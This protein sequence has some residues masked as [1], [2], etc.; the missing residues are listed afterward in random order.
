M[1]ATDLTEHAAR[2]A[3]AAGKVPPEIIDSVIVGN[4]MQV[5]SMEILL[6]GEYFSHLLHCGPIDSYL[7]FAAKNKPE[8]WRWNGQVAFIV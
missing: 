2:A 4:V 8:G 6:V 5:G 3:L 7:C 1:S